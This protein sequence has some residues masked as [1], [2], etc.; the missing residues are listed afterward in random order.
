MV[1]G[2]DERAIQTAFRALR[3][4]DERSA[5]P[6]AQTWARA[7]SQYRHR[8]RPRPGMRATIA[9]AVLVVLGMTVSF[10]ILRGRAPSE[11]AVTTA[12]RFASV[13]WTSPTDFLLTSADDGI[14]K[15]V[16][17]IRDSIVNQLMGE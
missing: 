11:T 3:A 6:F 9:A 15:T 8:R 13:V 4:A 1:T 16:P 5:P 10:A 14:F 7:A 12:P 2:A 17:P